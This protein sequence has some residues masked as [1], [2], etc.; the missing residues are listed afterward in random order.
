MK[1]ITVTRE[2]EAPLARVYALL[3]DLSAR[4]SITDHF[5]SEFR[6]ERIP[7][8]GVG[9]G[10]RFQTGPR[11]NRVWMETVITEADPFTSIEERGH[12]GRSDRIPNATSWKLRELTASKI[13]VTVS[14]RTEPS[15]RSDRVKELGTRGWYNRKWGR[16]LRKLKG[17]AES[18][19]DPVRIR[20]AGADRVPIS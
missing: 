11:R 19:A 18:R 10:A 9:A 14:F 16:A 12:G 8:D 1:S 3:V 6:V 5:M 4:P 20:I 13:E 7:P 2:I 17:I 15:L